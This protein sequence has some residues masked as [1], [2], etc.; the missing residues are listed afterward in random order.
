VT[1]LVACDLDR[2]LIYSSRAFWLE[3]TDADAPRIVVSEVYQGAP[4]SFMTR[5]AE[6]GLLALTREA[7]FVPVTTRTTAQFQRV[8]LPGA[9]VQYAI[10]ANGG[11]LL[12]DGSPDAD[13]ADHIAT[14][15]EADCAPLAEMESLVSSAW[16]EPGILRVHTAEDLFV[17]AIVD[18][19]VVT[20]DLLERLTAECASLGWVV[21]LQGRKL[22][23]V[24]SPITKE[25][26]VAEVARRTG[27]STVLAAGD[28]L[29]DRGMLAHATHAFRPRHGELDD[30]GYD[31][32][33]LTVT[34][35][36]GLLA[37]EELVGLLRA[38]AAAARR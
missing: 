8:R 29:L 26:A 28:S 22:Y 12:H 36:R 31:A 5:A 14:R 33:N 11:I 34:A 38:A 32:H 2:T 6:E 35:S 13:W 1:A 7:C 21:S 20:P 24:P 16:L 4:L 18:R 9:P 3:T 23:C 27:T 17:Y 25:A 30:A 15:R 37:G 19:D 10:T